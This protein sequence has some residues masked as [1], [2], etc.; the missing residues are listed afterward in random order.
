MKT[1]QQ[2]ASLD[3]YNSLYIIGCIVFILLIVFLLIAASKKKPQN[4]TDLLDDDIKQKL[5]EEVTFHTKIAF[6]VKHDSR[7]PKEID[8]DGEPKIFSFAEVITIM[9]K[10][11]SSHRV[12]EF[13]IYQQRQKTEYY[14]DAVE[15]LHNIFSYVLYR[16]GSTLTIEFVD[17][18]FLYDCFNRY[19]PKW[20]E[21]DFH[22]A[23]GELIDGAEI[24]KKLSQ[25]L[26][27]KYKNVSFVYDSNHT[28]EDICE[29]LNY[30]YFLIYKKD[31]KEKSDVFSNTT[32]FNLANT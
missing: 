8:Y 26:K 17:N 28:Q 3:A 18:Q 5:D 27:A 10:N 9:H 31:P 21:R 16:Y 23:K 25:N 6:S 14:T 19:L 11:N 22:N 30:K 15:M 12:E 29:T 7:R 13:C 2:L 4:L 1:L 32:A 24:W 20:E